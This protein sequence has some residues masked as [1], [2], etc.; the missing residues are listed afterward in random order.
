MND[1][2]F[3]TSNIWIGIVFILRKYMK[4]VGG[5]FQQHYHTQF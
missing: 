3:G 5:V 1:Y 2:I 4:G